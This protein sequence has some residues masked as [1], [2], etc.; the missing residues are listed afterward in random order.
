MGLAVISY[1]ELTKAAR[2]ACLEGVSKQ[3]PCSPSCRHFYYALEC[4]LREFAPSLRRS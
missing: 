3:A 1:H 4:F 2:L